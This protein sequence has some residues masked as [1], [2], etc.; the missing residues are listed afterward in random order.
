MHWKIEQSRKHDE[1]NPIRKCI[2][3]ETE[4]KIQDF[5]KVRS[6]GYSV[7]R[8]NYC[9]ECAYKLSGGSRYRPTIETCVQKF[10]ADRKR[11]EIWRTKD[12]KTYLDC[13]YVKDA[14]KY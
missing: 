7:L 8:E 4:K 3:C 11:L 2:I 5:M 6:F 13:L 12:K 14:G 1:R 9:T 10:L